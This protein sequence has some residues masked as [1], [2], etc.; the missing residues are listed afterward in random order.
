[1]RTRS[2][3]LPL[4]LA[5][6]SLGCGG[7]A[8]ETPQA[9]APGAAP[10]AATGAA[11]TTTALD[12]VRPTA[13]R[14]TFVVDPDA[15]GFRGT[16][17][18]DLE[19]TQPRAVLWLHGKDLEVSKV[20][21]TPE[22]G[23]PV[24]ATW[25]LAHASGVAAVRPAQPVGPGKWTLTV[26]YKAPWGKGMQGLYVAR[27]AGLS[28]AFTQFEAID[29]RTAFPSFDE[30][31]FKIPFSVTLL[32]PKGLAAVANTPEVKRGAGEGGFDRVEF[33]P[34]RP[35]PSYLV[36]FAAGPL[37]IV[38]AGPIAANA[39]RKE[40]LPFR[41][42]APKGRGREMA[43][44]MANTHGILKTLEEYLGVPYP[45]GKLDILA[46]P[47]RNGAM[48]NPGAI[49]FI[50]SALLFDEKT[51]SAEQK[52]RYAG[53]MAHELA[54]QWFGNLVTTAFWDDIWLNESFAT[55][56]GT[57][58]TEAWDP[59]T[60]ADLGLV[61]SVLRTMEL[62]ALASTRRIR[63][64]IESV[65][66]IANAFDPITYQKG[67]GVLSMFERWLGPEV[68]RKGVN[69]YLTKHADGA[70][71]GDDFFAAM[72]KAAGKDVAG[73]F[74]SFLDQPGLP[75]VDAALTCDAGGAR[76]A[77]KQSRFV[78]LGAK[79]M[80]AQSWQVPVCAKY[81]AD[82]AVKEA[83]T[84][85]TAEA[86]TL[87]L[88][89][90]RCPAWVLPNAEAAGYYRVGLDE[91]ALTKVGAVAEKAL[92]ARDKLALASALRAGFDRGTTPASTVLRL[93]PLFAGDRHA[94]VAMTAAPYLERAQEW[95]AGT[96]EEKAVAAYARKLYAPVLARLGYVRKAGEA[97]EQGA[98][99]RD[100]ARMMA[101]VG[102]DPAVRKELASRGRAY[103]GIKPGGGFEPGV[104]HP[105]ALAP[106]LVEVALNTAAE[107]G[108]VPVF[109]AMVSH[110]GKA[111]DGRLRSRLLEAMG[112]ARDDEAARRARDFALDERL[113]G[114][115]VG[116]TI[117]AQM[118]SAPM[119]E[120]TWSWVQ[121]R[122]DALEGR[123]SKKRAVGI[124]NAAMSYC[125]EGK[126]KEVEAF[127]GPRAK[128]VEGAPRR[129]AQITEAV[130]VCA[131]QRAAHE[132]TMRAFFKGQR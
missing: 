54:H 39:V 120:A 97:E 18:L 40:P 60:E 41:G 118:R 80:P 121:K 71:V 129:V 99:R 47:E 2:L 27:E 21:L 116:G 130:R 48:E 36:A 126:A 55:W 17:T 70:A 89:A 12:D 13:S 46:V 52:R 77:L 106:D 84:V 111:E 96:A 29:A 128:E 45:Y 123:L 58:T 79:E 64:P 90:K 66:D 51:A 102:R 72:S 114:P 125:D 11:A 62:D 31:R 113:R 38:D 16:A 83:C 92:T 8:T 23:A 105:E 93:L 65:H 100:A 110:L 35:I 115:E 1:M 25:T 57:R 34:T 63:Q 22:G 112:H 119:R 98:L 73:A 132:G 87:A 5:L 81:E 68:W 3:S 108:G 59:R 43:Y 101:E 76:L 4:T 117:A 53:V 28:Y 127:F 103:L 74:R 33:A 82:G 75:V 94:T 32:V 26:E 67:A 14:L 15:K 107:E 85:L 109:E 104:V 95:L 50:E 10:A 91:A 131:A 61:G 19:L 122:Y 78:P 69:G 7:A 42:V 30:P 124:A 49:T 37:D 86:G 24:A 6:L 9:A 20:T 44:A 88:P 56:L